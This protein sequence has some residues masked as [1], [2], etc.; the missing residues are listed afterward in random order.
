VRDFAEI[1]DLVI[2][3]SNLASQNQSST[4][5]EELFAFILKLSTN[6]KDKFHC[7][8]KIHLKPNKNIVDCIKQLVLLNP[9]SK[10]DLIQF[11]E[12]LIFLIEYVK[13][14]E[15]EMN[16]FSFI[17]NLFQFSIGNI[18]ICSNLH[19]GSFLLERASHPDLMNI[20]LSL[21]FLLSQYFFDI[22]MFQDIIKALKL[23]TDGSL[24]FYHEEILNSFTSLLS[25]KTVPEMRSFFHFQKEYSGF[26]RIPI[27]RASLQNPFSISTSFSIEGSS[28]DY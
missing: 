15:F 25:S 19:L 23:N 12:A 17:D 27:D 20:C 13:D 28:Q 7:L 16:V 3:I 18:F 2:T 11:P 9:S 4:L 8:P 21:F 22:T 10:V 24:S 14:T 5:Y 1:E 26:R 6:Y